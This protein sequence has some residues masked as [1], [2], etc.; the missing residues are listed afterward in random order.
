[1]EPLAKVARGLKSEDPSS[2]AAELS[3]IVLQLDARTG[4]KYQSLVAWCLGLKS[5]L[6]VKDSKFVYKVLD[7]LDHIVNALSGKYSPD[8]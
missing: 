7:P 6:I 4:E 5:D 8:L 1:M 3:E 2:W